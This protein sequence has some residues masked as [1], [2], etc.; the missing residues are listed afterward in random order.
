MRPYIFVILLG[1]IE[2]IIFALVFLPILRKLK[3]G[4]NIRVD[5]PKR[6]LGKAGTP[7]MGGII[8]LIP[9]L[10]NSLIFGYKDTD[11]LMV[12]SITLGFG[13]IGFLDDFLK[14]VFKRSLG[15]KANQKILGQ[16]VFS[17]LLAY[18]MF[19]VKGSSEL[20]LP[21]INGYIDLGW[22]Y[23]PFT[24]FVIIATV[25]SVNLTDGLDGLVTG[26]TIIVVLAFG[27]MFEK[28]GMKNIVVF[29]SSLIG[30]CLGFL[31]FNKHP[32]KV[33]MGDTGSLALGGAIVALAVVTKTQLFIPIIGMIFVFESLSVILQ[34]LFF[35]F[36]GKRIFRMSP[37]H[38]HFEL[39]GWSEYT[40]VKT[41][42][43]FTVITA[44][45]G[46]IGFK[47]IF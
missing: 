46:L 42:W 44:I 27:L 29:S 25:N 45:V 41:F 7:T 11:T 36:T 9:L 14:I 47:K 20:Y 21:F 17:T 18:Y 32:A 39:M 2:T 16:L 37:I 30:V 3:L 43:M 6:H 31:M 38:H 10:I 34:V 35:R 8:F 23:I 33:F 1:F 40:V 28:M 12:L 5:G 13:L 4:Q 26:I 19:A 24:V 22:F 15:L